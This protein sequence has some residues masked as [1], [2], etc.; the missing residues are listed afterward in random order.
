MEMTMPQ[1]F[2]SRAASDGERVLQMEKD[3]KGKFISYTYAQ[4]AAKVRALALSLMDL[5]LGRG[6]LVG[7]ISDNRA[8]WLVADLAI[9]SCGAANVPR[10]RDSMAGELSFIL[11]TTESAIVFVENAQMLDKILSI[12]KNLPAMRTIVVTDGSKLPALDSLAKDHDVEILL[13]G[14][15]V[16]KG[17]ERL[18]SEASKVDRSVASGRMD[19]LA[20]VIF[21]SG[22]TGEPKG[23]MLTQSN[24]NSIAA[25]ID[26]IG[27]PI[28]P[29]QRWLSVLPVWHSFERILQYAI[30]YLR[31]TIAYSKPIG[32][33][34]LNDLQRV[35]PHI[36]GS[37]PRIWETVKNG[38][39]AQMKS[40]KPVVRGLFNFFVGVGK[41]RMKYYNLFHGLTRDYRKRSRIVSVLRSILPLAI[42]TPLY[43]LGDA[44]V[45]RKIKT[46]LGNSFV[47][48]ISGGGSLPQAVD[49][50][51]SAIGI[52]VVDGYGLT[53]TSPVIGLRRWAK[54]VPGTLY[55]FGKIQLK[56]VDENG[57][58]C[59]PGEKGVLYAKGPQVMKGYYKRPELTAKVI[60]DE[61]WFNTGD[62]AVW[63][64]NSEYSIVGR[65][66]DTIVL[67]GGEN[68]EP[69]PIEETI[70]DSPYVAAS[71]VVG[72]DRKY[73]S[74]LVV[75]DQGM[76]ER[77]LKDNHIYYT[78]R[79]DLYMM[80]E[81]KALI[82]GEIRERVST[83]NGFRPFEQIMRCALLPRAFEV[84]RELSAKQEVK[85]FV[86]N[87]MYR[88]R[89]EAMYEN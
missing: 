89:I 80:P 72:Q 53:E 35:N 41:A 88:D 77:Y 42:L 64:V 33:I 9:Q 81:V 20:T 30:I 17:M 7:H 11:S 8:D 37:V 47:V 1:L 57:R 26:N 28:G 68:V 82:E 6:D 87:E 40:A 32:K 50:F 34:L 23:V 31:S 15:L 39:Y 45:F 3:S 43:K 52:D 76:V 44:L 18:A 38:V 63:T 22:T 66:K 75:I 54:R 74:A 56:I 84:N 79:D 19:E 14:D 48:G 2:F 27:Y 59:A 62:L 78:N 85:R 70:N 61:G 69:V 5:G 83:K 29:G 13:Q 71:V 24:L 12:R 4:V 58:L 16:E 46:K 51:F 49:E 86:V 55:P 73:L 36:M 25:E 21:T 60:D 67:S 65:A 10:G